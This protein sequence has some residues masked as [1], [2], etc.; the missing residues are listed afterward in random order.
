MNLGQLIKKAL[1]NGGL[2]GLYNEEF[3]CHCMVK[4][5]ESCDSMHPV[6]CSPA[7][8]YDCV[9]FKKM[10]FHCDGN[11]AYHLL[12]ATKVEPPT[13]REK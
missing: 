7:H 8:I 5:I 10:G 4:D 13:E 6:E 1:I 12:P 3:Q 9:G 2:H 11:C